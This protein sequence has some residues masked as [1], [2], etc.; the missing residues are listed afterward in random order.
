ME[1]VER[2]IP[3]VSVELLHLYNRLAV[4]SENKVHLPLPERRYTM[5]QLQESK[6]VHM[7]DSYNEESGV[8][9]RANQVVSG[10]P[11]RQ[12][13]EYLPSCLDWCSSDIANS[14]VELESVK[15]LRNTKLQVSLAPV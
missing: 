1:Q 11:C 10:S 14:P 6:A 9:N 7:N 2:L 12:L 4:N 5:V 15:L 13:L 3:S 8:Q